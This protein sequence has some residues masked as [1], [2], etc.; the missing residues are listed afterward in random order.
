MGGCVL[1]HLLW[2]LESMVEQLDRLL[3]GVEGYCDCRILKEEVVEL[4]TL[5]VSSLLTC[6]N[7]VNQFDQYC[8]GLTTRWTIMMRQHMKIF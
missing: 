6:R 3:F 8:F 1:R 5:F 7:D 2:V 4:P